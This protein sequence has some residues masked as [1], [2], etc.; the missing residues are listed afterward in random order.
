MT[1][2]KVSA[3]VITARGTLG[4]PDYVALKIDVAGFASPYVTL[5]MPA[6]GYQGLR[7]EADLATL[8]EAMARAINEA[9]ID[10][11]LSPR[12]EPKP[13]R[14]AANAVS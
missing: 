1:R 3:R 4:D 13:G 14:A 9:A 2:R 11:E 12:A 8:Y 5:A 7:K 6:V 10:V